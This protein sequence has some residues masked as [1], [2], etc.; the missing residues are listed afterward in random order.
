MRMRTERWLPLARVAG[1]SMA[2]TLTDGDVVVTLPTHA[3]R[4]D[5]V[6]LRRAGE[7]TMVKRIVAGAGDVVRLEA[8]RLSVNGRP[9]DGPPVSGAYAQT[10]TVPV[11]HWFV[12][13]DNRAVSSDSRTWAQ[14]FVAT[15]DLRGRVLG[16]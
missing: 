9:L 1:H 13:G 15:S 14:P 16:H 6:V 4:G 8:G 12:V 10:W 7:P 11:G 2:P 3:R 5:I